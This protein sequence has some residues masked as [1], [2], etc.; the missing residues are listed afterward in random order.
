MIFSYFNHNL[1]CLMLM[2]TWQFH[3]SN[4]KWVGLM[5]A[6]FVSAFTRLNKIDLTYCL[7]SPLYLHLA[8]CL[9]AWLIKFKCT[10]HPSHY[11]DCFR[12]SFKILSGWKRETWSP[13]SLARPKLEAGPV[14]GPL[15]ISWKTQTEL[16]FLVNWE[17]NLVVSNFSN[18]CVATKSFQFSKTCQ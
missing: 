18:V 13:E 1:H 3:L 8:F 7:K 15:F 6:I 10:L 9:F 11:Y 4:W 14:W 5:W 2:N 16:E 12:G 17:N